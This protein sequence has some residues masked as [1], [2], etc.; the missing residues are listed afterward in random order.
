M[1]RCVWVGVCKVYA[2]KIVGADKVNYY[3]CL[4]KHYQ[5]QKDYIIIQLSKLEHIYTYRLRTCVCV[6]VCVC[7][8]GSAQCLG[9]TVIT[10]T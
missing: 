1:C 2:D 7:C 4:T 3:H 5:W 8:E 6:C 10:S 9:H